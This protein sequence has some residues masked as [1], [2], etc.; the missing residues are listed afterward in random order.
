M[1]ECRLVPVREEPSK[2]GATEEAE[3][4]GGDKKI[5]SSWVCLD[6]WIK[7]HLKA[8]PWDP[9]LSELINSLYI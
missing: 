4:R 1:A 2:N 8:Y 7:P 6:S 5:A 9:Q 3:P